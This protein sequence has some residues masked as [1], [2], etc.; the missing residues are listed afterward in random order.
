MRHEAAGQTR[1]IVKSDRLG[2]QSEDGRS[3]EN[4][5]YD[6]GDDFDQRKPIFDRAEI[7]DGAGMEIQQDEGEAYRP[8][9]PRRA[10]KKECH[11]DTC[12]HGLPAYGYHLSHP[13]RIAGNDP[14]PGI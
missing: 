7:I 1:E 2:P 4:D 10:R 13:I 14:G 3:A 9:P 12:R 6:Y 11:V 8:H 5:E